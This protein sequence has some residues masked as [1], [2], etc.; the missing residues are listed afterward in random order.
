M[1]RKRK[2]NLRACSTS[3]WKNLTVEQVKTYFDRPGAGRAHRRLVAK[4]AEW[5]QSGRNVVMWDRDD[6]R[7]TF[8]CEGGEITGYMD[9]FEDL[10]HLTRSHRKSLRRRRRKK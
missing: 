3:P 8:K 1:P 6:N 2:P 7:T 10:P 9:Y 4:G 5:K